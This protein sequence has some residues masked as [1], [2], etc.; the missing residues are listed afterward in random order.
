[1]TENKRYDVVVVGGGISGTMA[2]VAAA[3]CGVSVL[4]VEKYG[5]LGGMLTAAGV[6]PMMTFHAGSQQVI[7]GTTGELIERL[8][9]KGESPGHLFDTTGFTYTVTPFNAEGMKREL[10]LMVTEAA[11]EILYHTMLA[12]VET[13]GRQ[14]WA[15]TVCNKHGLSRIEAKVFID[16]TGDGDLSVWAGVEFTKGRA[17]DGACQPM[18]MKMR[19]VNVNMEKVRTFI[20]NH[21]EEFP[22]LKG[23]T[24]I[25]DRA[26]RLSIGG[27]VKT[28]E[29]ARAVGDFSIPREDLLFFEANTLGEVII[30]TTRIIGFDA[31]DPQSLS[32]AEMEGRKQ[33]AELERFLKKWVPGFEA[34]SLVYTGPQIGVRSSRQIKGVYT[35]T[36][37]DLMECRSF[38]D[39]I[40]HSG[41]P[42]DIHSP[43][44]AGTEHKKLEWGGFY[45]IPYRSLVNDRIDNLI[46]V[47]RCLSADFEAQAAVRTTPTMGA[48]GQ[49]G[50]V[51]AA[52]AAQKE[53]CVRDIDI[54][55]LR[56]T[57]I[58]QGAFLCNLPRRNPE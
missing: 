24:S 1:M 21:P 4:L 5:F 33:A 18:T 36:G 43:T 44:G 49:A 55:K 52:I 12:E 48:V 16:A 53:I 7:Q 23:D 31:N 17:S 25:I 22:R 6:G 2:A 47:G 29:K 54:Q 38:P 34:A 19:M 15:V 26:V 28:L 27:F 8:I 51:A 11:G 41:Y 40:A 3:R 42:I 56:D 30:N 46:T 45:N 13:D 35:L 50:G 14:V 20:K 57:L 39:T 9:A 37:A 58:G 32:R 10:E